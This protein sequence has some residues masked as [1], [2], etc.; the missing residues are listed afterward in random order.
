[1]MVLAIKLWSRIFL[2]K[3][4]A[5]VGRWQRDGIIIYWPVGLHAYAPFASHTVGRHWPAQVERPYHCGRVG[6]PGRFQGCNRVLLASRVYHVDARK[7]ASEHAMAIGEL[8]N[9]ELRS[10]NQNTQITILMKK[11]EEITWK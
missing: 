5:S 8:F 6:A 2:D 7:E 9:L 1:M 11:K 4:A 3:T 10:R